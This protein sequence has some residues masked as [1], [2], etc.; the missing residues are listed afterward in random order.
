MKWMLLLPCAVLYSLFFVWPLGELFVMA[1]YKTDFIT[2]K[3]VGIGNYLAILRDPVYLGS[4]LNSIVLMIILVLGQVGV[5]L[6]LA[7]VVCMLPKRWHDISRIVF[8]VPMLASGLIIGQV[9]GWIFANNGL[10][11]WIIG[12]FGHPPIAYFSG[13]ISGMFALWLVLT[14]S[15]FGSYFILILANILSIDKDQYDAA[16]IDGASDFQIKI[17]IIL[18][19]IKTTISMCVLLVAIGA[20]QIFETLYTLAPYEQLASPA[21][22]IYREAF[23]M[24]RHGR[25]AS[26]AVVLMVLTIALTVIKNRIGRET[27]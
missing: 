24:S 18:P 5:A 27:D 22:V 20:P 17:K 2:S 13:Y 10:A 7:L 21:Y 1:L 8:Y 4:L 15:A 26:G 23:Q 9:W 11:N 16:R 25:A 14:T 3:F 6:I 12:L 19:Q